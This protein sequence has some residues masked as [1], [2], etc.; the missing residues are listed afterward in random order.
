MV[1]WYIGQSNDPTAKYSLK[2]IHI[3][4]LKKKIKKKMY[5][6]NDIRYSLLP[7]NESDSGYNQVCVIT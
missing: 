6:Y 7:S 3:I 5:S 2:G 4:S 1:Y